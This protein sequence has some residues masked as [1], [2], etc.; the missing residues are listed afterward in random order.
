MQ[1]IRPI[2]R[3]GETMTEENDN[4]TLLSP[5]AD[6]LAKLDYDRVKR[7]KSSKRDN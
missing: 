3:G 7:L 1:N 6:A 2:H 4:K 5:K